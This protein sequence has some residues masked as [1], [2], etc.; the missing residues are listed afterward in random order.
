MQ[1][2]NNIFDKIQEI[3]G[4]IPG[5]LT[6]LEQQIDADIQTEYYNY[7]RVL[8]NGFDQDSILR[9]KDSIF[10]PEMPQEEKKLLLV[11]MANIDNIEVYRTLERFVLD[12][13]TDLKDWATLALQENRLLLESKLL[14]ENQVLISTGLGGKG[15]KLRYFTVLLSRNGN[16]FTSFEKK[17]IASELSYTIKK[18]SGELEQLQFNKELCR[19]ISIIPLQVPVQESFDNMIHECNQYGDFLN[20]DYIITNVKIISSAQIRK[21][22]RHKRIKN[23]TR[24]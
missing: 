22:I 15:M 1:E 3:L 14:D 8:D 18:C 7:V 21:L 9:N 6:I 13:D 24:I 10:G 16:S 19:I 23:K 17:I 2:T 11:Q 4:R 5:N 20:P 12:P